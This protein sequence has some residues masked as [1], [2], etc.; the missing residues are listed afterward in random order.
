MPGWVWI[1]AGVLGFAGAS[2]FFALAESALFSM[3]R[4]QLRRLTREAPLHA[5]RV[6]RLLASRQDLLATLVLGSSIANAGAVALVLWAGVTASWDRWIVVTAMGALFVVLVIGGEVVPKTL[7]ARAPERWSARVARA[8]AALVAL[9]R[10]LRMITQGLVNGLIRRVLPGT[11]HPPR[12]LSDDEY[13]ELIELATL[14][15]TL[16]EAEKEI[17]HRIV[18]MDRRT[19][20]DVM[21]PRSRM[22][23]LPDDL[24]VEEMLGAA[25]RHRHHRLPLF[26]GTPD[27]IVG[28]LNTRTLLLDPQVDLA[29][30]IEFP[31]FVP[32]TTN[33]FQLLQSFQ[34]QQRGLA[35]VLDEY[36][37]TAGLVT[38]EDIVRGLIGE[39]RREGEEQ[40]FLMESLGQGRWRVNGTLRLDDFRREVPDLPEIE[41]VETL[42]GWVVHLAG[43]VPPQGQVI[44]HQALRFTV[45]AADER[46]VRELQVEAPAGRGTR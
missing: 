3:G 10:P 6:E 20:K 44:Q 21:Q 25:R 34:R 15:G 2:F 40:G 5:A 26:D 39:L 43:T 11:A 22:A 9:T 4:W 45:L 7:A 16:T 14:R 37:G 8:I 12:G 24:P 13:R 27:T 30:A 42:G 31:S 29:D 28:V 32:D 19:V 23:C 17:I 33:L 1:A 18:A 35:V 38:P 46:R 41:D 36:G